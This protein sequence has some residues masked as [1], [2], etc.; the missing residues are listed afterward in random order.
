MAADLR[1]P[2]SLHGNPGRSRILVPALVL[3]F[4]CS[5]SEDPPRPPPPPASVSVVPSPPP[6]PRGPR[7]SF[8][9]TWLTDQGA[10]IIREQ[11][12]EG[13][14]STLFGV[15]LPFR[16]PCAYFKAT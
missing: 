1:D 15:F 3:I 11:Q 8:E 6:A 2:F 13:T 5:P 7:R 14:G 12:K 4:S 10:I 16:H 9:G